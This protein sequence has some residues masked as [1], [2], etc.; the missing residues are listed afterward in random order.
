MPRSKPSA[1]AAREHALVAAVIAGELEAV[2]A[3]L[4]AGVSPDACDADRG[5]PAVV[6]AVARRKKPIVELLMKRGANLNASGKSGHTALYWAVMHGDAGL[7]AKL[8]EKGA[9]GR[10]LLL[11]ATREGRTAMVTTLLEKATKAEL[12]Q[13]LVGA[14]HRERT[15]EAELLLAAGAGTSATDRDGDPVLVTAAF[16]GAAGVVAAILDARP[17]VAD[18]ER[19]LLEAAG[20]GHLD[21]VKR[22]ARAGANPAWVSPQG[23]TA[24][25]VARRKKR[26]AVVEWLSR[27]K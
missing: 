1:R 5:T 16:R 15:R 2:R 18:K 11:A 23:N 8:R 7:F 26:A 9:K 19:A 25:A 27:A 14:A 24:L 3:A 13:A 22:L 12:A 21:I 17:K 6:Y 4:D 20:E 10:G